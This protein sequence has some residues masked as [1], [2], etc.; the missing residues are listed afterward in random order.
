MG[1]D[2]LRGPSLAGLWLGV[3]QSWPWRVRY[4]DRFELSLAFH[5]TPDLVIG[6]GSILA[7]LDLEE[8]CHLGASSLGPAR[9][10]R[11]ELCDHLVSIG[12]YR[13]LHRSGPAQEHG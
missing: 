6:L 4:C 3:G 11:C 10:A 7:A 8:L 9:F 2:Y 1:L 13:R 5:D 12:V